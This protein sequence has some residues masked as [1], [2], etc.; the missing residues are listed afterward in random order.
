[1]LSYQLDQAQRQRYER[2]EQLEMLAGVRLSKDQA[3]TGQLYAACE[4]IEEVEKL[5]PPVSISEERI[6]QFEQETKALQ[7]RMTA[8]EADQ[9]TRIAA[10]RAVS[11]QRRDADVLRASFRS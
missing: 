8:S 10:L 11:V 7:I 6:T 9:A 3:V 2:A 4:A 1:M 5:Y